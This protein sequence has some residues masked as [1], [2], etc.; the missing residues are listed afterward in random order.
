VIVGLTIAG[1]YALEISLLVRD[2]VR[3]K[4]AVERDG[5]TR[6][7][8]VVAIIA[9]VSLASLA[10]LLAP[11]LRIGGPGQGVTIGLIVMWL[12]LA[13]RIWAIVTL[14]AAFRTTVE[15]DRN[16]SL[17]TDGP[18]S[19]VR[20]PSYSGLLLIVL[21][22]GLVLGNWL[23]LGICA[24]LPAVALARRIRVEEA[25]LGRVLGDPYRAYQQRTKR[26]IPCLW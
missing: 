6:V 14:G 25:E 11:A 8:N 24:V 2:R 12:G 13:I 16:Q 7:V 5:G 9:S 1:W 20:H 4:G 22:F 19:R 17:I 18:Y 26:L 3:G 23:A 21:G 15:V 10:A